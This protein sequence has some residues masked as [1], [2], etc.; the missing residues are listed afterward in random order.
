MINKNTIGIFVLAFNRLRH[1]RKV[2]KSISKYTRK[3]EIVYI[4]ADNSKKNSL[5]VNQVH[6]Y[7]RKLN[8]NKFKVVIR[9]KNF[10]LKKNWWHAYDF[11]FKKYDKVICLEDDTVIKK[12]FMNFMRKKLTSYQNNKK[13]MSITGYAFP[14]EL[15]KNYEYDIFFSQRSN[16]WGQASWRRV[17]KLFKKNKED[18]L[19]ILLNKKKLFKL[20]KGGDD[21]VHMFVQDYLGLSNSIQIWWVWNILKNNGLCINP[22]NSQINNIGFDGTG[23]H[24]KGRVKK[25]SSTNIAKKNLKH[26]KSKSIIYDDSI[27]KSFSNFFKISYRQRILYNFVP[28]RLIILFYK[29]KIKFTNILQVN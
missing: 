21:I 12:N 19:S 13:I 9:D 23:T 8:S 1:L 16:A 28:M 24:Y 29:F 7:L 25:S 6:R 3:N 14:I 2:I 5:R 10:G 26:L 18:H 4:F 27:S 17:W 22:V 11:M 20:Y 15:P